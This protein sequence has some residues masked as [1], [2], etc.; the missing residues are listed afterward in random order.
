MKSKKKLRKYLEVGFSGGSV[1]KNLL[2]NAGDTG[3][4]PGPGRSLGVKNSNPLQYSCWENTMDRGTCR[5]QFMGSQRVR[6]D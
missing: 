2:V 1:L 6:H 4:I 5:L 3:L